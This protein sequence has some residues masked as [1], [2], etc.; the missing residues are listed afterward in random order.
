MHRINDH[1]FN[2]GQAVVA[3]GGAEEPTPA[4]L[5]AGAVSAADAPHPL[6]VF[7]LFRIGIGPSSSHTVGPMRAGLA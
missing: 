6:S 5:L 2:G 4:S 7:D 1:Y 3:Q